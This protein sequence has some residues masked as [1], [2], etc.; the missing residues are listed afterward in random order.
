[1]ISHKFTNLPSLQAHELRGAL[2]PFPQEEHAE[3]RGEA[4]RHGEVPGR[5]VAGGQARGGEATNAEEEEDQ[6]SQGLLK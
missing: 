6:D 3:D 4:Q 5:R 2:A 1:M